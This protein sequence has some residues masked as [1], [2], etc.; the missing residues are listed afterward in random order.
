MVKAGYQSRSQRGFF[1]SYRALLHALTYKYLPL[2]SLSVLFICES[3]G[4]TKA[5]NKGM[6]LKSESKLCL[7]DGEHKAYG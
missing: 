6:T 7:Q 1:C 4:P 5:H 2:S 3:A